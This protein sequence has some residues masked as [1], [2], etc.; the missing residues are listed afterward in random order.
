M[1]RWRK[2]WVRSFGKGTA[3]WLGRAALWLLSKTWRIEVLGQENLDSSVEA[4]PGCFI[5]VWHGRMIVALPI[6]AHLG[7]HVL[8]SSSGDGDISEKLLDANGYYVIRGSS[9]RGG[10]RA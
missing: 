7:W 8:V 2:R 6:Y 1:K 5:S 9:S 10:A 4:G 3:G